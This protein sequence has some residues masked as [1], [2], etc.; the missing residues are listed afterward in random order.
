MSA[1]RARLVAKTAAMLSLQDEMNS[2]VDADWI[3]RDREWYRAIW[4][5]CAELMDHYGGWKWWKASHRDDEQVMLEIVDIWHFGLSIRIRPDRNHAAAAQTIADAWLQPARSQGF[6]VDVET[7][8]RAALDRHDVLVE[9][10]PTLLAGIGRDFDD[11]YRAYV[12]KNVLNFFRQDHG[13]R[14]GTYR[15]TWAGREDNAHLV[16]ILARLDCDAPD[17][18]REVYA[19]LSAAYEMPG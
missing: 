10:I 1:A 4:I 9:V 7:L 13:Y 6:L 16:E 14:D 19:A 2:R 3:A 15:K 12:G 18:R 8:A 11:L 17:F 5:E